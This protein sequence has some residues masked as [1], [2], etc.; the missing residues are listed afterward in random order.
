MDAEVTEWAVAP[1]APLDTSGTATG[2]LGTTLTVTTGGSLA[3]GGGSLGISVFAALSLA[4]TSG[5]WAAGAGWT[6]LAN[7]FPSLVV[8]HFA[9]DYL[10]NPPTQATLS[11]IG[12]VSGFT[13]AGM[14]AVS[15]AFLAAE[16]PITYGRGAN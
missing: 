3:G 5:T 6:T 10:L 8:G 4:A 9:S 14:V 1:I 15:A 12:T 7:D 16:V 11:E 2:G 13:P